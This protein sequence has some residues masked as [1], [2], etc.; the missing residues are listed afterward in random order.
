MTPEN[1]ELDELG[2]TWAENPD[3]IRQF[4]DVR[5]QY[6][7]LCSEIAYILEKCLREQGIE[8][9]AVTHKK[10]GATESHVPHIFSRVNEFG[11]KTLSELNRIVDRS[12][13]ARSAMGAEVPAA[14]EMVLAMAFLNPDY[15]KRAYFGE[16][17]SKK[18]REH[19]HLIEPEEE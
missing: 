7:Q 10:L 12:E 5:P 6:E 14:G 9:S 11:Y 2:R 16:T 19:E 13:K 15:R 18:L 8:F 4:I 17:T 1:N 3:V